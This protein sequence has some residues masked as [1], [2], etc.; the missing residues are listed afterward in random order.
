MTQGYTEKLFLKFKSDLASLYT[1][2]CPSQDKNQSVLIQNV[3]K[4][5]GKIFL[6]PD[7]PQAD[8][9]SALN[10]NRV[11]VEHLFGTGS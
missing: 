10:T 9:Q 2:L 3:I 5:V 4:L 11:C 6:L 1:Y 8:W 7:K